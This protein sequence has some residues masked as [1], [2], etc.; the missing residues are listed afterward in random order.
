ME[1]RWI[2]GLII[3]CLIFIISLCITNIVLYSKIANENK[4]I[5]TVTPGGARALM[6]INILIVIVFFLVFFWYCYK[7]YKNSE[8]V[9]FMK[10]SGQ[11]YG[12]VKNK[13]M[14]RGNMNI[15]NNMTQN[16]DIEMAPMRPKS[17]FVSNEDTFLSEKRYTNLSS[18]ESNIPLGQAVQNMDLMSKVCSRIA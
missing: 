17:P 10:W 13:F 18:S 1:S 9:D 11:Q 14:N 8:E 3:F 16:G 15:S 6:I 4:T 7:F 2:T 12:N 5:G